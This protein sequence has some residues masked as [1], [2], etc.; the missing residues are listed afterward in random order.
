M[1]N[2]RQEYRDK[3]RD[4]W[5][6]YGDNYWHDYDEY[7]DDAWKFAVGASLTTAAFVALTC[8]SRTV[9][10]NGITY[11]NCGPTWYNRVYAGGNVTMVVVTTPHG[12]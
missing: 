5:Q 6:E 4:E 8:T 2:D 9:I 3:V 11:Y 1:Q 12:Y 7:Y 10:V